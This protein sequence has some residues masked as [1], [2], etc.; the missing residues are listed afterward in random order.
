MLIP[1]PMAVLPCC[2]F[3][4]AAI[5]G[6]SFWLGLAALIFSIGHLKV[7]GAK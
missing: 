4:L 3:F 2:I 5:I 1:I 6:E 7:S